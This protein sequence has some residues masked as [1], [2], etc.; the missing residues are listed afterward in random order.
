VD[1]GTGNVLSINTNPA[2]P[3]YRL[4]QLRIVA[5]NTVLQ[6]YAEYLVYVPG[7]SLSAYDHDS[8]SVRM[9]LNVNYG[10][11]TATGTVKVLATN[12]TYY[13]RDRNILNDPPC[14]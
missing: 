1:D 5:T 9:D 3:F 8:P 6:G 7:R 13:I 10:S 14:S 4:W 12:V 2:S 11:A